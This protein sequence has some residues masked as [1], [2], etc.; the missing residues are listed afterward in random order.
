MVFSRS[1]GEGGGGGAQQSFIRG[2]SDPAGQLLLYTFYW[3][4]VPLSHTKFRTLNP[5]KLL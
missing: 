5:F 3:Q 4:M 1:E 2:I